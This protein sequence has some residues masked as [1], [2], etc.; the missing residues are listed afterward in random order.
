MDKEIYTIYTDASFDNETKLATYAIIIMQ[1]NDI[2][3][4][5]SKKCPIKI[6]NS[7]EC[8]VF[9][10]YQAINFIN[11]SLLKNNELQK[12]WIRT[13]CQTARD[14]F[15]EKKL[16]F[17]IFERDIDMYK[18]MRKSYDIL[19]KALSKKGCSF[20]IKWIP[21]KLNKVAHK[22]SY[23]AFQNLKLHNLKNQTL[24]INKKI[25]I[26]I[27]TKFNKNQCIILAY[28]F[29]ILDEENQLKITQRE[30]AKDLK[31]SISLVNKVFK[32]FIRL[33]LLQKIKNGRYIILC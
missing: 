28:L 10:I 1:N 33:N 24:I 8:E 26:E 17:K 13:D 23:L 5:I 16:N 25:F 30:V 9:A 32:E 29:K 7:V 20:R 14:F 6:Q 31:I 22:Y 18:R 2:K 3:K 21:E 15:L 4:I 11:G 19:S 12:F 27:L